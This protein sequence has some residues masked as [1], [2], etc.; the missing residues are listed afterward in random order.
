MKIK[1][2]ENIFEA[3][4][5][6]RKN[7]KISQSASSTVYL[8]KNVVKKISREGEYPENELL[9]YKVM[10]LDSAKEG[11]E[12]IFPKTNIRRTS[13]GDI[14]IVQ[15][16][17]DDKRGAKIA[18]KVNN[19]MSK[20]AKK[21]KADQE[22]KYAFFF[23]TPFLNNIA[24]KGLKKNVE[25]ALPQ[26]LNLFQQNFPTEYNY[27]LQFLTI[28]KK[29]NDIKR[30]VPRTF[31]ADLHDKNFA[32]DKNGKI[33][34]FDFQSPHN[35]TVDSP[36]ELEAKTTQELRIQDFDY[37]TFEQVAILFNEK[38]N[39]G[40][41]RIGMGES[42]FQELDL[43]DDVKEKF[44]DWFL[45]KN[46]KITNKGREFVNF[47]EKN[48]SKSDR[49]KKIK[50]IEFIFNYNYIKSLFDGYFP[51]NNSISKK[52]VLYFIEH[53]LNRKIIHSDKK[54]P[55]KYKTFGKDIFGKVSPSIQM[56]YLDEFFEK[57]QEFGLPINMVE[58][59]K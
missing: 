21:L 40:L 13:D 36:E 54:M 26:Y 41:F 38:Y 52:K 33:K 9:Q 5:R 30:Q 56:S 15:E 45:Y 32:V 2:S 18:A 46:L 44:G 55:M 16:K 49:V 6:K 37:L 23:L 1:I 39:L 34:V 22:T 20:V 14:V 12:S 58:A 28:A 35:K 24:D 11:S 29:I 51:S 53:F 47:L 59:K 42:G 3:L 57:L 43:N 27:F 48:I 7:N 10:E 8:G 19:V 17:L 31:D 50:D 4:S 25:Q